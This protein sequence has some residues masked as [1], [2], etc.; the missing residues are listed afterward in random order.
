M[1]APRLGLLPAWP[2][3]AR[4]FSQFSVH[5]R[6]FASIRVHSRLKKSNV[7]VLSCRSWFKKVLRALLETCETQ[8][9]ECSF[10]RLFDF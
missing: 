2:S 1:L 8:E 4:R 6:P 7:R 10:T 5:S 9:Q 3:A